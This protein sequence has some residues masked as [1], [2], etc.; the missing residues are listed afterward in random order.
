MNELKIDPKTV[1]DQLGHTVHVN[2][3]VYTPKENT[4]NLEIG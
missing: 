4:R 1:A 3:N 2:Q